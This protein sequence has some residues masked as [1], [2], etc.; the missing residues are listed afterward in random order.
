LADDL[1]RRQD[2]RSDVAGGRGRRSYGTPALKVRSET[3]VR[4]MGDSDSLAVPDVPLD[5]RAM[6]SGAGDALAAR[7][8]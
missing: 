1:R 5:E 2:I 3:L 7:G 8:K 4:L 6:Q